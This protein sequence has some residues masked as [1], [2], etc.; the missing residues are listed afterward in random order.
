MLRCK[1]GRRGRER[2]KRERKEREEP[3]KHAV[4]SR[5]AYS[6]AVGWY[7]T[8]YMTVRVRVPT[9]VLRVETI[10]FDSVIRIQ[11]D[12]SR[13]FLCF[14]KRARLTVRVSAM[15]PSRIFNGCYGI[16]PYEMVT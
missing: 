3:Q 16:K 12:V 1:Q 2:R 4:V 5:L 7:H 6:R 10:S 15:H 13:G 9:A 8:S 14:N 11:S